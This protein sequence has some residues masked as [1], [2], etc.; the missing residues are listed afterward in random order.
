[1]KK[2]KAKEIEKRLEEEENSEANFGKNVKSADAQK[3][4]AVIK[5][6]GIPKTLPPKVP[7]RSSTSNDYAK[8]DA[9]PPSYLK[10]YTKHIPS[11]TKASSASETP[12]SAALSSKSTKPQA[13]KPA[14]NALNSSKNSLD[15]SKDP[16]LSRALMLYNTPTV[17][18]LQKKQEAYQPEEPLP[19]WGVQRAD[20]K[21]VVGKRTTKNGN[22]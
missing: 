6:I 20:S 10:N 19:T 9:I 2:L 17:A 7:N 12:K 22:E 3:P 5:E 16:S 18:S 8:T 4:K 13:Q 14:Q 11:T 1:M 21:N 15:G